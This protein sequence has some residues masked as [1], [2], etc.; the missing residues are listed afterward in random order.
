[1]IP[2]VIEKIKI[3][4]GLAIPTAAPIVVVNKIIDIPPVIALK[5]IFCLCNQK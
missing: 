3:K 1:M 2:V 5:T 4:L